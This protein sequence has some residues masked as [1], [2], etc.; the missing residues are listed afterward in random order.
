MNKRS[1]LRASQRVRA[2]ARALGTTALLA[3]Q[4]VSLLGAEP[5]PAPA[6]PPGFKLVYQENFSNPR[7]VSEWAFSDPKAWRFQTTNNQ[8]ALELFKQSEYEPAVRS[9]VNIALLADKT[10]ADFVLETDLLQTGKEYGHRDMCVYFGFQ[11]PTNF[12]YVHLASAADDHAHNIFIVN[13]KPRVKIAEKTTAGVQWGNNSWHKFRLVRRPS[14][15][16]IEVYFDDLTAP[17]MVAHDKTFSKG[18]IGFGSFD[19]T[20]MIDNIRIWAA[21]SESKPISFFRRGQP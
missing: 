17:L 18:A 20:G 5:S 11:N 2:A 8:G 6:L 14:T 19:D 10:F 7:A 12:Y 3:L 16:A 1:L 9:P 15:G 4:P 21:G 13:G